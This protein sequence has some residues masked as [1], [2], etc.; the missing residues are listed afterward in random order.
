M[1]SKTFVIRD[2]KVLNNL[3]EFIKNQDKVIECVVRDHRKKREVIQN[4]LYWF[5][6]TIIG[7]ELGM[8][9]EDVHYNLKER[10]LVPI[11]M[12]DD[13]EYCEMIHSIKRM[14]KLG[15][16]RECKLFKDQII[17]LTSTTTAT[18]QQFAEYLTEMERDSISKGIVLPH[19]E[20]QYYDALMIKNVSC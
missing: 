10:I 13:P 11:Y 6:I 20:D 14:R 3:V 1:K 12:R 7:H 15:M 19:K 9:K 2:E 8:T 4:S 17:K 5:W 16:D 18:V